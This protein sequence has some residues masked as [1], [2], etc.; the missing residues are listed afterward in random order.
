MALMHVRVL[1][2]ISGQILQEEFEVW[3]DAVRKQ[4]LAALHNRPSRP[5]TL[6]LDGDVVTDDSFVGVESGDSGEVFLEFT[7]IIGDALGA[8]Q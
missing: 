8:D 6:L 1:N 2:A 5:V 4:V 7:A 3:C